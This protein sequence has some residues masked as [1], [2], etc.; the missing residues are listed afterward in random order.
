MIQCGQLLVAERSSVVSR[1]PR[2][3]SRLVTI[4][5]SLQ[6]LMIENDSHRSSTCTDG[7]VHSNH[8]LQM[9]AHSVRH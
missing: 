6:C 7:S 1:L 8:V 5:A 9:I 4:G 3:T 2:F